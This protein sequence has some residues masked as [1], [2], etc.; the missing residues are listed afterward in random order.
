MVRL[1]G[2][3]VGPVAPEQAPARTE[4]QTL[5]VSP[6]WVSGAPAPWAPTERRVALRLGLA[7]AREIAWEQTYYSR[8]T[9]RHGL[10]HSC[11]PLTRY[12]GWVF[13]TAVTASDALA[14]PG[15]LR[16]FKNTTILVPLVS[17]VVYR[18]ASVPNRDTAKKTR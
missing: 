2:D 11:S 14:L 10:G 6:Y 13:S 16:S 7:A 9:R 12:F 8:R 17:V 4:N 5:R 18:S 1:Q 3:G 15:M